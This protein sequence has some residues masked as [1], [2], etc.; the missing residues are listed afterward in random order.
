M[1]CTYIKLYTHNHTMNIIYK[2]G[3][4]LTFCSIAAINYN[5]LEASPLYKKYEKDLTLETA[6][7]AQ[8]LFKS[9][10]YATF[11]PLI[12]SNI[13]LVKIMSPINT[14][15]YLEL[16]PSIKIPKRYVEIIFDNNRYENHFVISS[17]YDLH[18]I[19]ETYILQKN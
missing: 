10:I 7:R 19:I 1:G 8:I 6:I 12:V 2:I 5:N 4:F 14:A 3:S 11:W 13:L 15:D 16:T 18:E 17:K 9:G